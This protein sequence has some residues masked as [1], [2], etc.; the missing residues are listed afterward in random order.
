MEQKNFTEKDSLEL[1][2]S[3]IS[4]TR[5]SL[6]VGSGNVFLYYGYCSLLLSVITFLTSH[7]TGSNIWNALWFLMF[8]PM[9]IIKLKEQKSPQKMTTYTDRMLDN[10]WKIVA[11]LMILSVIVIVVNGYASGLFYFPAMLPLA[12]LTVSM[13]TMIT[14]LTVKENNVT[15]ISIVGF[16]ISVKLLIDMA[17]GGRFSPAWNLMAGLSFVFTLII[18]GHIL[19]RKS[20]E[21]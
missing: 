3:M 4:K 16:I 11:L 7:L 8:L 12:L 20:K 17:A 14:G 19:N 5:D 13:G 6:E 15:A 2:S 21:S 1:I 18:P 10:T 9:I